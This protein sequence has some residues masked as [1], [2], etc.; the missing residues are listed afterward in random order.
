MSKCYEPDGTP[1][2]P[3]KL[4]IAFIR[5]ITYEEV[6]PLM[7]TELSLYHHSIPINYVNQAL[8]NWRA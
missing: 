3:E 8:R 5:G 2:S 7:V 6:T 4:V 1:T